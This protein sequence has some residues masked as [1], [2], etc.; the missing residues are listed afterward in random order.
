MQA[1]RNTIKIPYKIDTGS[2]GNIMLLFMFKKLFKNTTEEQLQKSIK[3]HIRLRTYN[4]TNITQLGTCTVVIKFKNI[5][6]RY[7]F[8][9]VPG[10]SQVLLGMPYTASLKLININIDSIQAET[11]ECKTNI[12]QEMHVG[13]KGCANTNAIQNQTRCQQSKQPKQC[14]QIN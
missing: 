10:N 13:E 6:K 2:E 4:K 11:V 8:F 14:K 12:E 5:K 3:S 1:G 9:V 7:V